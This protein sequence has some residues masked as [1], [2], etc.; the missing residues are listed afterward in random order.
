M[1]AGIEAFS[2]YYYSLEES[3]KSRY[4]E[5]LALLGDPYL[6]IDMEQGERCLDWQNWLAVEYPDIFNYL[7]ATPSPYTM[8]ELKAYKSL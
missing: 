8:Q 7:I 5:K 4:N 2:S 1:A 3:S 6:A